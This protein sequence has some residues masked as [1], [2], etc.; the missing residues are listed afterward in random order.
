MLALAAGCLPDY[1]VDRLNRGSTAGDDVGSDGAPTATPPVPA[2]GVPPEFGPTVTLADAPPP[3]SGGTLAVARDGF[4]VVAADPD[5]DRVYVLDHRTPSSLRTIALLPH[6]EP[7]RVVIDESNRAYVSLRSGGAVVTIDLATATVLARRDVC[8]APRGIAYDDAEHVVHV[9]C[10]GGELVTLP[11]GTGAELRRRVLRRDLRDVVV[12]PGAIVVSLFRSA[13]TLRIMQDGSVSDERG[14]DQSGLAGD[15]RVAWR[16]ISVPAENAATQLDDDGEAVLMAAQSVPSESAPP[17]QTAPPYYV[18]VEPDPCAGTGP[19]PLVFDRGEAIRIPDAVLPVDLAAN[20]HRIAIVAAGNGHT[21]SM[22]QLV[23]VPRVA[24]V[25]PQ[26]S[27]YAGEPM[28]VQGAQLTSVA[29]LGAGDTV[30][31][32]SRE[33]AAL[34]VIDGARKTEIARIALAVESRED[35]GHAIF[36]A[37][38]GAGVAC[39]SCHAEGRDDGHSWRSVDL[40]PRRTP[41]LLGTLK[42]TAPYHWNGEAADM[43]ALMQ[44]TFESRMHGPVLAGDRIAATASWLSALKGLPA[45]KPSDP[46]AADRGKTI[47]EGAGGCATCHG[48]A[49]HTSNA[50]VDVHTGGAFQVPSLVGVA[51]RAPYLHDGR[52]GSIRAL[53]EASHGGVALSAQ[54]VADVNAYVETF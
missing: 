26:Y 17:P 10:A 49:M 1:P 12:V 11:A 23:F 13:K 50:T 38:S 15:P 27:C 52:M 34:L 45:A 54:Q 29:F 21:P 19:S 46:A 8:S 40:G 37:N 30:V 4:T 22:A 2:S 53:L 47:F 20:A 48:G 9:A 44:M 24:Q 28:V 41:S 35:T 51:W 36:H 42:G 39:A 33:P 3:L 31:A 25:A 16:M 7:G 6:D 5:R 43:K 14:I 32:L 18:P